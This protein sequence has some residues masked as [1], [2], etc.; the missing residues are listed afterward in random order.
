VATCSLESL[1]EDVPPDY[2][3]LPGDVGGALEIADYCP[4]YRKFSQASGRTG[5]CTDPSNQPDSSTG[6]RFAGEDVYGEGYGAGSVCLRQGRPWRKSYPQGASTRTIS[7]P[8][9]GGGCYQTQCLDGE[10]V[11]VGVRDFVFECQCEG[12]ELVVDVIDC[13]SNNY[14]GS[15]VCPACSSVC[16]DS[17]PSPGI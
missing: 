15:V 6:G 2:R 7:I 5:N 8:S 17:C 9:Y 14:K 12:Q 4:Y 3:Y 16:G 11:Y 1:E 13:D 10:G